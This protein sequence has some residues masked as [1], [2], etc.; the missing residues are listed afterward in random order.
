MLTPAK[1]RRTAFYSGKRHPA[2]VG[3]PE[4]GLI[5]EWLTAAQS[6]GAVEIFL[7]GIQMNLNGRFRR[8]DNVGLFFHTESLLFITAPAVRAEPLHNDPVAADPVSGFFLDLQ[9]DFV[10]QGASA[11]GLQMASDGPQAGISFVTQPVSPIFS[12]A[13]PLMGFMT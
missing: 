6:T 11:S 8:D 1:Q 13:K 12:I 5:T 7:T 4:V 9:I 3:R 10:S 2:D